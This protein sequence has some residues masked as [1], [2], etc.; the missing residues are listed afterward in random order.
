MNS[1]RVETTITEDGSLTLKDIP[2]HAGDS[3]EV[4]ILARSAASGFQNGYALRGKP[5]TYLDP[6][7]PVDDQEWE[8]LR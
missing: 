2:F 8:S 6:T 4:I 7:E 5:V 3:V 1:H